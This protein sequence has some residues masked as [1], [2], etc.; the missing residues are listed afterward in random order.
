MDKIIKG[1][2]A[3]CG[4]QKYIINDLQ[5]N[6]QYCKKCFKKGSPKCEEHPKDDFSAFCETCNQYICSKFKKHKDYHEKHQIF[7]INN[8]CKKHPKDD[9][10]TF[11][12]TCN[13]YICSQFEEHKDYHKNHQIFKKEEYEPKNE[14]L[15]LILLFIKFLTII[16][17]SYVENK[18]NNFFNCINIKNFSHFIK[19]TN[20]LDLFNKNFKCNIKSNDKK[21]NLKD[22]EIG[23]FGFKLFCKIKFENLEQLILANNNISNI[24]DLKNLASPYLNKLNLRHNNIRNINIFQDLKFPLKDLDLSSNRIDNINIFESMNNNG[25]KN[26]EKLKLFYNNFKLDEKNNNIQ[27]QIKEKLKEKFEEEKNED[28]SENLKKIDNFNLSYNTTININDKTIDLSLIKTN[29]YDY[30]HLLEQFNH[31][32][33][34]SIKLGKSENINYDF[35]NISKNYPNCNSLIFEDKQI[36]LKNPNPWDINFKKK[37]TDLESIVKLEDKKA[38]YQKLFPFTFTCF[39]SI[40]NKQQYLIYYENTENKA[41]I[42]LVNNFIDKKKNKILTL[43]NISLIQIRY[44]IDVQEQRDILLGS[45]NEP[46]KSSIYYWEFTEEKLNLISQFDGGISFCMISDKRFGSN[47]I[48]SSDDKET[49][50]IWTKEK[51]IKKN[52]YLNDSI[53]NNSIT[54]YFID[55]YNYIKKNSSLLS[56]NEN[57]IQTDDENKYYIIVGDEDGYISFDFISTKDEINIKKYKRYSNRGENKYAIVYSDSSLINLIGSDFKSH[58][59]LIFSFDLGCNFGRINLG[60]N[61]LS[62]GINLWN[63]QYLI[64]CCKKM[65]NKPIDNVIK[66]IKIFDIDNGNLFH[67]ITNKSGA[68][69][70]LKFIDNNSKEYILIEYLDGTIELFSC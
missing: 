34:T 26:L 23:D 31:P 5:N 56:N 32:N 41:D 7:I 53:K 18:K 46:N 39:T 42:Y 43:K 37:L 70:S 62:L 36:Y 44:Y 8:K 65:E 27:K 57:N 22:K 51:E 59:I 47:F 14:E 55:S 12:E 40:N 33:V 64:V 52:I 16:Y 63:S 48:I 60:E 58:E 38:S 6:K 9:F 29:N 11:C 67:E 10:S 3:E 24:D 20:T 50:Y 69:F 28:F 21:I 4:K 19:G 61:Y 45:V 68:L 54:I 2:C 35:K 13:Q 1:T 17:E 15:N 30:H 66:A 25:L 49:L